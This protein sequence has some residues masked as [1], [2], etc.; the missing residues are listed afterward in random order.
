MLY[1]GRHRKR[2]FPSL[3]VLEHLCPFLCGHILPDDACR[4]PCHDAVIGHVFHDH[5]IGPNNDIVSYSHRSENPGS[6]TNL[7]IVT[8]D[9]YF[10]STTFPANGNILSNYTIITNNTSGMYRDT[11]STI[12]KFYTFL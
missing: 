12:S 9:G 1:F 11:D 8:N 2:C 4:Y 10:I 3:F 6:C 5:G 7:H